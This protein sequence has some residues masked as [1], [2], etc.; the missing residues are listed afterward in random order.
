MTGD[1]NPGLFLFENTGSSFLDVTQQSKLS[2][3][4]FNSNRMGHEDRMVGLMFIAR[5]WEPSTKWKMESSL[6]PYIRSDFEYL[7]SINPL[8]YRGPNYGS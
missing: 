3:F 8:G 4:D 7:R 6:D 5:P 2:A 1:G